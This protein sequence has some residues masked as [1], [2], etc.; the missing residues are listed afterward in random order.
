MEK[1]Y[2][3][4][5]MFGI[6]QTLHE[7][8]VQGEITTFIQKFLSNRVFR[9]KIGETLS[10]EHSQ[11]E[12]VPQRSVLSCTLFTLAMNRISRNLPPDVHYNLFVDD[13][14]LYSLSN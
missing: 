4:A 5:W 8:G 14:T 12:G 3:T 7:A 10:S 9:T 1:A 13:F 6:I 2:D 11:R